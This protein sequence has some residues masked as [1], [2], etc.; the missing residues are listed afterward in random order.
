MSA[1]R[2]FATPVTIAAAVL[3]LAVARPQ[4]SGSQWAAAPAPESVQAFVKAA[5]T[6]RLQANDIPDSKLLDRSKPIGISTALPQA[7]MTLTSAALPSVR[8]YELFLLSPADAQ[9]AAN[10]DAKTIAFISVDQPAID[11]A[12]ATLQIG[13]DIV[14]PDKSGQ[15]KACC[16]TGK[17]EFRRTPDGWAFVKWS[18]IVCA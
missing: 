17:A 5:L 18:G 13:V 2:A 6:D 16:C 11:A 3:S 12:S 10:R 9:A 1:H 14:L 15:W 8:G 7:H 4:Q